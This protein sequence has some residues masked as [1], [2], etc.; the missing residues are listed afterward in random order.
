M[1]LYA[2]VCYIDR[3]RR[4]SQQ[5]RYHQARSPVIGHNITSSHNLKPLALIRYREVCFKV[6]MSASVFGIAMLMSRRDTLSVIPLGPMKPW[7]KGKR[8]ERSRRLL[9]CVNE[10]ALEA[11][12]QQ[13][14]FCVVP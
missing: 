5:R 10:L 1:Y 4:I 3:R 9:V 6:L 13:S 14:Y 11:L 2:Y 8:G 12:Y 7:G